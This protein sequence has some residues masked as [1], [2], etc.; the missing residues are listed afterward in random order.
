LPQVPG[1]NPP[2]LPGS[3]SGDGRDDAAEKLLDFLMGT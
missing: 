3:G 2:A 1:V